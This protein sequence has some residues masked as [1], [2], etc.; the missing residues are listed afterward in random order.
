MKESEEKLE[1]E[2]QKKERELKDL[3]KKVDTDMMTIE[4]HES[5]IN[6]QLDEKAD[7]LK[8]VRKEALRD[9]DNHLEEKEKMKVEMLAFKERE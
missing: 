4:E 9:I 2:R 6:E 7:E 3:T 5:I 8:R 1:V